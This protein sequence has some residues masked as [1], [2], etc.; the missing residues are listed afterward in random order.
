MHVSCYE[1]LKQCF[2]NGGTR[3]PFN[4]AYN[5]RNMSG[6]YLAEQESL[7][8]VGFPNRSFVTIISRADTVL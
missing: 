5:V 1:D 3:K 4:Y 8:L 6:I 7:R 2:S